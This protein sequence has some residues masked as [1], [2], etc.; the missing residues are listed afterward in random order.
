MYSPSPPSLKREFTESQSRQGHENTCLYHGMSKIIRKNMFEFVTPIELTTE[1]LRKYNESL[2]NSYYSTDPLNKIDNY[3]YF[4]RSVTEPGAK[5][6][7][8]F[9]MLYCMYYELINPTL[10]TPPKPYSGVNF[11]CLNTYLDAL[12]PGSY[13][14]REYPSLVPKAK[15]IMKEL[16][17]KKKNKKWISVHLD[18]KD[19]YKYDDTFHDSIAAFLDHSLYILV[20]CLTASG[21]GHSFV[22]VKK[23][24]STHSVHTYYMKNTWRET[25]PFSSNL[26]L[27]VPPDQTEY[28]FR[29]HKLHFLLPSTDEITTILQPYITKIPPDTHREQSPFLT[30]PGDFY[31]FHDFQS[32]M[33]VYLP[34]LEMLKQSEQEPIPKVSAVYDWKS[35]AF[36][37]MREYR[38]TSG[39]II[40]SIWKVGDVVNILHSGKKAILI[41][42]YILYPRIYDVLVLIEGEKRVQGLQWSEIER[43]GGKRKSKKKYKRKTF[44]LKSFG[45][46]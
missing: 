43:T 25:K 46:V 12:D 32:A 31:E 34:N 14:S 30:E 29:T 13:F 10:L 40:H 42:K 24:I 39:E 38:K 27:I 23:H 21:L 16:Q 11:L 36:A 20:T 35:E 19:K 1:E 15:T 2:G 41:S 9:L 33:R 28:V 5:K 7:V 44:K 3:A 4:E 37:I 6:I 45:N 26:D 18:Y 22:M 17:D 8:L